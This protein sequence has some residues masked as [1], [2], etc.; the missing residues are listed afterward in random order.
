MD[1]NLVFRKLLKKFLKQTS[2]NEGFRPTGLK[3]R[4]A[5]L[6]YSSVKVIYKK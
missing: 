2:I 5:K 4:F 1:K 6:G 3:S